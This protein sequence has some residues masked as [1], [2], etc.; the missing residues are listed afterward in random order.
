MMFQDGRIGLEKKKLYIQTFG[1]QMNVQDAEKMAALLQESGYETT[2][3]PE[4]ADLIIINTCSIREKAA[5]KIYSQLGRFRALKEKRPQMIIG[6]GGCLAQQ[7]GDRF[8]QKVPY[9]D[10]VFGTHQ[11]HRLPE[12]VGALEKTGERKVETDFCDRVRSLDI[13]AQL[14]P[15]AVTS[16]VTIMQGCN[17]DCAYCVVPRLRGREESRPLPEI[18]SEVEML[19]RRGI[20]EV[21]L[22]GQNVNSYGQTRNEGR[23]FTDLICTL[24][25]IP[26][27]ERIRFTTSHPKDLSQRLIDC[28][29]KVAPLCEHIHLPVQSGSDRVLRLMNRGYTVGM[30]L[31]KIAALRRAY[32]GI[33]I[34]SDVILGFP[35]EEEADFQATLALLGEVKFDNLFSFQYSERE[36]TAAAGMDQKVCGS[37][38]RER[39]MI[40]QDL[41]AEHTLEKNRACVGHTEKVLVEGPSKKGSGEMMGRTRRNRIVN[42]PG[43]R[44]FIGKTVSV[45]IAEAFLHSLHGVMEEKG[46]ADVH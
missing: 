23:D 42:F 28:F 3:D 45:R 24:G 25:G 31:E 37:V 21:T 6:V 46:A 18:V 11:I 16:F 15:G 1:C 9:L 30:Y 32:P 44:E 4:W 40:L 22:L 41:Q 12:L 20:R 7:W 34:T 26:G 39:L 43:E 8:F 17:N 38:K 27:I 5:Q 35:G 29:G 10:L 36:G 13:P 33:S 14:S 19:A 2:D